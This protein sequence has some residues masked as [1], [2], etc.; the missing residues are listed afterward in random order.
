MLRKMTQAGVSFSASGFFSGAC[1]STNA[2]F[3]L[4]PRVDCWCVCASRRA[5][6]SARGRCGLFVSSVRTRARA[7]R[8]PLRAARDD[9]WHQ[10]RPTPMALELG[11]YGGAAFFSKQHNLQDLE[12]IAGSRPPSA[13]KQLKTGPRSRACAP[14]STRCR[15]SAPKASSA[16][17]RPAPKASGRLAPPSGPTGCTPSRSTRSTASCR[18]SWSALAA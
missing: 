16:S 6:A 10:F 11:I 12:M 17:S 13:T 1:R 9:Y 3:I 4:P 5:A 18:S 8:A 14:A 2:F 15:G 7:L